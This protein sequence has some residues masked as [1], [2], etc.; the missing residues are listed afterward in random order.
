MWFMRVNLT[1]RVGQ[2]R[3]YPWVKLFTISVFVACSACS[4]RASSSPAIAPVQ[5]V[6]AFGYT[7]G[8]EIPS[9]LVVSDVD[10]FLAMDS[11]QTNLPFTNGIGLEAGTNRAI[12]KISAI[13]DPYTSGVLEVESALVKKYGPCARTQD[14]DWTNE[15][16]KS[17]SRSIEL[18]WNKNSVMLDFSDADLQSAALSG[19]SK[20]REQSV[21]QT[22]SNL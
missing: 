7:L 19:F 20:K 4:R 9:N 15:V 6:G 18:T 5:I 22:I 13:T 2:R 10:G 1:N 14:P 16:W 12:Y 8:S 11:S 21:N 17:G 3:S